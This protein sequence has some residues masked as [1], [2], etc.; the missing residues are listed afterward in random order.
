MRGRKRAGEKMAKRRL[1]KHQKQS[2]SL[3]ERAA[4][5][6]AGIVL[7]T[8]MAFASILNSSGFDISWAHVPLGKIPLFSAS[9]VGQVVGHFFYGFVCGFLAFY[10]GV[11]LYK[12]FL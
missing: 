8:G 5:L 6:S 4:G 7:G 9:V 2:C 1:Q 3:N 10:A 11:W 12:K